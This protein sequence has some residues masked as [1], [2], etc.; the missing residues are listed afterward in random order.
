MINTM[1]EENRF[2][3]VFDELLRIASGERDSNH[4]VLEIDSL[5][6]AS[7]EIAELRRAILEISEPA[8]SL[9]TTT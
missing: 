3:I 6:T 4:L 2:Q 8:V 7:E 1:A 5:Q 9:Y